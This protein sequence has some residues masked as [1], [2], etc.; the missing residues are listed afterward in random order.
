MGQDLLLE[1]A[2]A[3]K[4]DLTARVKQRLNLFSPTSHVFILGYV[5]MALCITSFLTWAETCWPG[6]FSSLNPLFLLSSSNCH[7]NL[8]HRPSLYQTGPRSEEPI[9]FLVLAMLHLA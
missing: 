4:G 7:Y 8:D 3:Y 2:L 1:K 5:A 6:Y 9:I